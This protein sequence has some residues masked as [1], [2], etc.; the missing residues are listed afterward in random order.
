MIKLPFFKPWESAIAVLQDNIFGT[1]IDRWH[2]TFNQLQD[3]LPE[4]PSQPAATDRRKEPRFSLSL[5]VHH[6]IK[7]QAA[8]WKASSSIDV[9]QNG[10]RLA[11]EGP[12]SVGTH[13]EL[14]VK[15]PNVKKTVR[16]EGVVVWEKPSING[17]AISEC[18]VAFES[19]R[20]GSTK[21]KLVQ[22]MA[23]KLC[24]MAMKETYSM[25]CRP[26]TSEKDLKDAYA[27]VYREYLKRKYCKADVSE[28]HYT[29]YS[30][31]PKSK[32]FI[33]E[34]DQRVVGT[35]SVII[36]SPCGI[37]MESLFEDKISKFRREGRTIAEVSL[38]ALD[39]SVFG[40]KSFSLTD[41]KKLSGSFLLFKMM[42]DYIRYGVGVTDLFITMHPKHKE[43]YQYLTFEIIGPVRSYAGAEG[44]PALP[45]RLDVNRTV[46]TL[47]RELSIQRYFIEDKLPQE[48]IESRFHW[49]SESISEFLKIRNMWRHLSPKQQEHL[50]ACYPGIQI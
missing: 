22:F 25:T 12:V 6:R 46:L 5:P 18:G 36:D 10:I 14:D 27:L 26:A 23:D 9:S 50:K 48:V 42:F 34:M 39:Q 16:M 31:L 24:R 1:D 37:P 32:T 33:L 41:F 15:L 43:L 11:L 49:T 30:L 21:G 40:R 35:I 4:T 29:V 8:D 3:A 44:N 7:G 45:M 20:G 28:L 17:T 47:P 38:L 2:T 13:L 19:L